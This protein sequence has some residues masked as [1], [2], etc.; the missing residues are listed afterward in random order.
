MTK[1]AAFQIVDCHAL[2]SSRLAM[3]EFCDFHTICKKGLNFFM[4]CF[5]DKSP[6]NDG[7]AAF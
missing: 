6:R 5:G 7:G 1:S 3:T 2:T 4:D